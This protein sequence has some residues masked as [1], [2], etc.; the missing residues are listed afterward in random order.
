M[1]PFLLILAIVISIPIILVVFVFVW[2]NRLPNNRPA[3]YQKQEG[4]EVI[5]FAGDSVTHGKIGENYVEM[6]SD[7]LDMDQFDIVNAGINSHLAWNLLQRLDEIINC[8]PDFVTILIGTNDA[9]AAT[10][11]EEANDYVKRME[12]PRIPD[13]NWYQETLHKIVTSLQERTHAKIGLISIP[14]IGEDPDHFAFKISAEHVKTIK[15]VASVTG[16]TYLPFNEVM[17]EYLESHPGNPTYPIEKGIREMSV[18]CFKR[19]ILRKD[20]DSIGE[21][22][23]FQLHIDYLHLNTKGASMLTEMIEAFIESNH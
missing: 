9:N 21:A 14:P 1:I 6:M 19:Y 12:L 18:A 13:Q 22:R 7:R 3:K 11:E 5:V 16:V 2:M 10:S 20:W 8:E 15:D 17:L 4:K 23:G